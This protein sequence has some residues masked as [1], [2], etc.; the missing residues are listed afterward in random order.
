MVLEEAI[1]A[2]AESFT[3]DAPTSD[4]DPYSSSPTGG[5]NAVTID[6]EQ[7]PRSIDLNPLTAGKKKQNLA[8]LIQKTINNSSQILNRPVTQ[9]EANALAYHY[10]HGIRVAS[11]GSPIGIAGGLY[12]WYAT[13]KKMRFPF[14]QPDWSEGKLN[15]EVLGP[16]RGQ[17][18]RNSWQLLRGNCYMILG[19]FIGD[20]VFSAYGVTV[21]EVGMSQDRRLKEFRSA[22]ENKVRERLSGLPQGAQDRQGAA[23]QN[24]QSRQEDRR[25][26]TEQWR[27]NRSSSNDDGMSPT[28]GAYSNDYGGDSSRLAGSDTG[29]LSD[30]QM[31][32]QEIGQQPDQ[33]SSPTS[34]RSDTFSMNKVTSQPRNFDEDDASPT[35][36]A[37]SGS[38]SAWDKIRRGASASAPSKGSSAWPTSRGGDSRGGLSG[39]QREQRQGSTL[40]DS[41]S[42]SETDEER[43]LA[44]TEAQKEFDARVERERRGGDFAEG[45]NRGRKW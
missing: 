5:P 1:A 9:D 4:S 34:S 38:A 37:S 15:P 31:R 2:P 30:A 3:D 28:S 12:R 23:G 39:V 7:L 11:F 32:A 35:A 42:F 13:G 45:Q 27:M 41:F 6:L 10:A 16:L 29:I 14:W 19:A 18:A 20:A 43:E 40:G 17:V 33:Q 24:D 36:G 8:A 25:T 21:S 44:K 26:A 22:L